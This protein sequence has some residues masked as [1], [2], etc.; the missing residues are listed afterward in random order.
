M[1]QRAYRKNNMYL[2]TWVVSAYF[3]VEAFDDEVTNATQ[4]HN[5]M[6]DKFVYNFNFFL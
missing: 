1:L 6:F 5:I 2:L 4:Q 3:T